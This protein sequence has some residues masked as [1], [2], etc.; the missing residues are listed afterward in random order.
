MAQ[1]DSSIYF[2]QQTPDLLGAVQKGMSMSQ[3]A[4]DQEQKRKKDMQADHSQQIEMIARVAPTIKDQGTYES[5]IGELGARGVD[6]SQMPKAYDPNLVNRYSA[7]A[8]SYKD[9]LDEQYRQKELESKSLDRK[10]ARDERRYLHGVRADE[11]HEEKMNQDVQKLSK[12]VAGTQEMIGA[13]DEV[14]GKLGAPIDQFKRDKDGELA[15]NGK[16]VDL[17]GASVPGIG[18]VSFYSNS[19][20]ELNSA[21][22]RVFNATL[23]DRSGGA[24]TDNEME[25]LKREFNEG[26]YNTEAEL[27][28]A[29]QRYK[30]QTSVVLKNR[31]AGYKPAVVARYTD[32]GGRTSKTV[33]KP[34][35]SYDTM[36][37]DQLAELYNQRQG[38]KNAKSR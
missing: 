34:D 22:S 33:A 27:V 11:R 36:S 26:K 37:D 8:L 3:M 17:P 29:L 6:V 7:M 32:Q 20:R 13:L 2:Q 5:A 14:E 28:D 12:D 35:S 25:R 15:L 10:E 38:T 4:Y 24:V 21:A 9:K 1:I 16:K 19:A 30:R 18:R 23:K 31:E